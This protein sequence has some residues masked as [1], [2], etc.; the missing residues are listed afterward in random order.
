MQNKNMY[1][2][3]IQAKV[4][5]QAVAPTHRKMKVISFI[6]QEDWTDAALLLL[7]FG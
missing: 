6:T 5:I 3:Q 2:C 4:V 7:F 1:V